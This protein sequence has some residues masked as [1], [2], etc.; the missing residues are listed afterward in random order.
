MKNITKLEGQILDCWKI[1]DDLDTL[2]EAIL[3]SGLS[4]DQISNILL[5]LKDL[6]SLKFEK[7]FHVFEEL[8]AEYYGSSTVS[9]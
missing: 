2:F 8:V 1:T 5:G 7:T 9:K 3:E 4:P 6:Y